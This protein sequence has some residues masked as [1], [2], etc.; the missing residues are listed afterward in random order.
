MNKVLRK[1]FPYIISIIALL[2]V[3]FVISL[4]I[5]SELIFPGPISVFSLCK[6]LLFTQSFWVHFFTTLCRCIASFVISFILGSVLG[7]AGGKNNFFKKFMALPL[8]IIRSTP[9][10]AIILISIYVLS[11]ATL[12]IFISILMNLPIIITAYFH[13]FENVDSS[14]MNM[15]KIYKFSSFQKLIYIQLPGCKNNIISA[16]ISVYGLCWKV[17]VAGE[18][19]C[20]PKKGLGSILQQNQ[21]HLETASVFAITI[22]FVFLSWIIELCFKGVLG[23]K[24]TK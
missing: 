1:I 17:V 8:A 18:V 3:W 7:I 24:W 10:I 23:R 22:L 12:P 5:D 11:S 20:L 13:G 6:T 21:L 19:L 4:I 9:V 15:A 14:L 16:L 2:V